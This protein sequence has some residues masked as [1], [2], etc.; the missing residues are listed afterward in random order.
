[1]QIDI[2]QIYWH[3]QQS[4][5]MSVDVYPNGP[6]FVTA[7]YVTFED[8][9]I[10]FWELKNP[11]ESKSKSGQARPEKQKIDSSGTT[12]PLGGAFSRQNFKAEP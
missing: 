12:G 8:S 11:S 3:D 6:Y 2:P 7:S 1:M 9:G 5:L 4:K 10:K